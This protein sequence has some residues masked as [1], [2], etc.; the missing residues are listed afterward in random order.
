MNDKN[1]IILSVYVPTYG[2]EKY[3][4]RALD[5]ILMQKT[6][7]TYEVLV[8]EDASPDRTR[9]ILKQYEKKYP[10]RFKMFYRSQNMYGKPYNNAR[11]L[12]ERCIGKYIICLEGDDYW[13]SDMKIEKQIS[14][15]EKHPEYI[16]VAHN[17]VV[18]DENNNITSENYSECKDEIYTL[19]HYVSE[20]LPG[21]YTTLMVRNYIRENLFDTSILN[22]GLIPGDRLLYFALAVHGTIYCMQE[23]M[24]AYRHVLKSGSSFSANYVYDFC[25][26]ENWNASL[27]DYARKFD[28]N[29]P[30]D[31]AE[32]LYLRNLCQGIKTRQLLIDEFLKYFNKLDYKGKAV[33]LYVRQLINHKLLNKKLWL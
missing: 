30:K 33:L 15:L 21:Q 7:Y 27:M 32:M 14:F 4:E 23:T 17:C 12:Q 11:D 29:I 2:H 10:D 28:M 18:V 19:K 16:A 9:E 22:M 20:I 8:G 13:I 31:Y 24:S 3:I 5:S 6:S 1:G 25:K 26:Q